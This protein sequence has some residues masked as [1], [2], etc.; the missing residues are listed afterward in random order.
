M[1]TS[2]VVEHLDERQIEG[3]SV[4]AVNDK[5]S[6]SRMEQ[7]PLK[8]YG[9]NFP[10][11]FDFSKAFRKRIGG[12]RRFDSAFLNYMKQFGTFPSPDVSTD[13]INS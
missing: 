8:A 5:G 1:L 13:S 9:D 7:A 11:W 3:Q 10:E 4:D 12:L 6:I 2:L